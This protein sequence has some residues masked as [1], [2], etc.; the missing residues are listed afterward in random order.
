MQDS[1][2]PVAGATGQSGEKN[3]NYNKLQAVLCI[4]ASVVF[5]TVLIAWAV[6]A[7]F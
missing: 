1:I 6:R 7:L 5:S 2:Q 4:A 3:F